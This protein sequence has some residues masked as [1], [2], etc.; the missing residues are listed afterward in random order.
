[1]MPGEPDHRLPH[2]TN[3][4]HMAVIG[5][6]TE[7]PA[8][9]SIQTLQGIYHELTGK[10]EDVAKT[11]NDPYQIEAADLQQLNFRIEQCY[12]QYQIQTANCS[13]KVFYVNDTRET[14]SSFGRFAGFNAG[15]TSPVESVLIEYNF[16]II[17]PQTRRPQTYKLEIRLASRIAVEKQMR[18]DLPFPVPRILRIM[19]NQTAVVNV[20]YIDYAVAR[21]MLNTVDEWLGGLKKAKV[22]KAWTQITK[23]SHL[24][25]YVSRYV[26]GAIV[27]YLVY[28]NAKYFVAP[29]ASLYQLA[30]FLLLSFIGLFAAYRLARH[31]G[32]AAESSLDNWSPLSYLSLTA[33]DKN[34]I[35]EARSIN[36]RS[37]WASVSKFIGALLVS[38][39]SGLIVAWLISK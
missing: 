18:K 31:L 35:A 28:A 36:R 37:V 13:V 30:I 1:M 27:A 5:A 33:G 32:S 26:V 38:V 22:S 3:G 24:L 12:E 16:L 17:L 4:G 11:Y 21:S 23:R 25:P 19:G 10:S 7:A 29:N 39:L 15:T 6:D 8:Q 14:F 20:K 34:L 9:V 2:D